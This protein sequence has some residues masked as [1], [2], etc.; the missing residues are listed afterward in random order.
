MHTFHYR[1]VLFIYI[2]CQLDKMLIIWKLSQ[3]PIEICVKHII[4]NCYQIEKASKSKQYCGRQT[5]L[6]TNFSDNNEGFDAQF[7]PE[8][9][10]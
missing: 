5:R 7:D 6:G 1:D 2:G 4:C 10:L 3:F 9:S 8:L